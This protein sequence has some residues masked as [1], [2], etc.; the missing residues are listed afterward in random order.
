MFIGWYTIPVIGAVLVVP[1]DEYPTIQSAIDAANR[2]DIILVA[3]GIYYENIVI[4]KW[5]ILRGENRSTTIIDGQGKGHV[6]TVKEGADKV[7]ISGFTIRNG[8]KN[9]NGIDVGYSDTLNITDNIFTANWFGLDL[10]LSDSNTIANNLFIDNSDRNIYLYSCRGNNI[11]GNL[12][13]EGTFGIQLALSNNTFIVNNNISDTSYGIYITHSTNDTISGNMLSSNSHGIYPAYSD[14]IIIRNNTLSGSTYGILAYNST[15]ISIINNTVSD[16]PSYG[17][18]LAY[19]TEN[20]IKNNEVSK[21]DWGITLYD[22]ALNRIIQNKLSLNTY[23]INLVSDSQQ[24]TIYHNNF[25]DNAKQAAAELVSNTWDNGTHGN[26]WS[27]YEGEDSDG[28]GIGNTPYTINTLNK[29]RYPLMKPW[30]T[31]RNIAIANVTLSATKIYAGEFVYITVTVKNDGN[32][33]EETFNVTVRYENV[34]L[35]IYGIV[36]I[37]TVT[38][39][40]PGTNVT[41]TFS[42]NTT[43]I[44]PCIYYTIKAEASE[45]PY[46]ID[47]DDNTYVGGKVKIR[48]LGDINGDG[49]IDIKDLSLVA[50]SYGTFEGES[51]YNPDA[52]INRDGIIDM[53]DIAIIA[54]HYGETC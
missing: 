30:G 51:D 27:D 21:N 12:I 26:Y 8:G 18:Y 29:D 45:V 15:K 48:L 3:A 52:D 43:E 25:V 53:R 16:N 24:N 23:G 6:V 1:S 2:G 47:T 36:A 40:A 10:W 11:H 46:E 4:D 7:E 42:W 28:D 38:N 35:E 54:I 50:F 13:Y 20:T 32:Y 39:L 31:Y 49:V 9:Y 17:V 44:Q 14:D 41:L 19:S 37:Q 34:T 5:L 33:A 22:S